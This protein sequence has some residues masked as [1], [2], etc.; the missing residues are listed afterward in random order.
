MKGIMIRREIP[1]QVALASVSGA[2]WAPMSA[3]AQPAPA[4]QDNAEP[5]AVGGP[6]DAMFERAHAVR[7]F[8]EHFIGK[9]EQ[10]WA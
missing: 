6:F 8:S 5:R 10:A 1:G 9:R 3:C 7:S 4:L 2:A